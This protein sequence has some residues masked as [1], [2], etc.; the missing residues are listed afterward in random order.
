MKRISTCLAT[1]FLA[2][3]LLAQAPQG[4]SYQAIVRN[5][6]GLVVNTAVGMRISILQGSAT[7]TAVYVETQTPTTNTNGLITL[8]IGAGTASTGT[9]AAIDWSTGI[10]FVKT[11]IDPAGGTNYTI[12]IA[13]QL[14]SVPYALYAGKAENGFSGNYN[15]LTNK[16]NLTDTSKFLKTETDP[17]FGASVAKRIT[18][19]DTVK[20]NAKSNFSGSYTDLSNRPD[21]NTFVRT[22]GN[23]SIAGNKTFTG[24][25]TGTVN[26]NNS[27]ITNV[28]TPING[29]DA[30]N[31]VYV[32]AL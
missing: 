32:D 9:F 29:N 23:Q 28:A 26:A 4:M 8:T 14:L 15:D 10:Y 5:T 11:E 7:G 16:P 12:T 6:A 17:V 18:A 2:V 21:T 30:T 13:N 1:A 19:S 27:T 31:K 22:V 25:I 3:N 24:T 20:W